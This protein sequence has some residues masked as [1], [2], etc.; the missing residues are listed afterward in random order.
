MLK[1]LEKLKLLAK[2]NKTAKNK[3]VQRKRQE[4]KLRDWLMKLEKLKLLAKRNKT[5]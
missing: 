4:E 3:N 5:D 2:Q 1:K